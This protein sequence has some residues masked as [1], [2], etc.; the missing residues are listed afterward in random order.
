MD[1]LTPEVVQA[2]FPGIDYI[3]LVEDDGPVAAA[4]YRQKAMQG[5]IFSTLDVLRAP[6]YSST[7]FDVI[8]G[9]TMDGKVTGAVVLFHREPYLINDA[10]RTAQLEIF[11]TSM[12][13][14]EARLGAATDLPPSFVAGATISARSMRNAVQEGGRMVLSYRTEEIIVT[15]RTVD[16]VNFKPQSPEELVA[17]G[18][19]VNARI[20]NQSLNTA[21]EKAG[22]TDFLPEIAMTGGPDDLYIDFVAGYANPPMIGRNGAGLEPYDQ[23][24]NG[25]NEGHHG[26][27]VA[28]LDGV[29]DHRGVRFNNLSNQF[30]LDR[31]TVS[32]NQKNFKF[33]KS[34]MLMARG[35]EADILVLPPES[36]FD[37]MQPWQITLHAN[38]RKPNGELLPF[39][40]A[41]LDYQLS[42]NYI[43]MPEASPSAA[44]IE[45]WVE[46]KRDIVILCVALAF[47]TLM[48][49]GQDVLNSNRRLHKVVRVLFLLFTLIWI[50]WVASAQLSIVHLVNYLQAPFA[51]LDI[52]FYLMEPLIVILS[53]YTALSV[54]LIGRGVFCGWLCPFGALQELLAQIARLL[55]LPRWTPSEAVQ[56]RYWNIK[57]M[58]LGLILL[59]VVMAPEAA[60]VAQE[61]EPFKTAITAK[62]VR[63]WPYLFYAV[64]LLVI[65]LFTERAFC[66][67]LC[68]LGAGLAVLDRL[69]LLQFLKRRPE[70]CNPC[71]LCERSCPVKA[72]ESSGKIKMAECFLCLDCMVEYH[73]D[74]RCPP[75]AMARK[76][77][78]RHP[79]G[80]VEAAS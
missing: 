49:A 80:Q 12:Q 75:L 16:L 14:G 23:L 78:M 40:L 10:R 6:G 65:G 63:G 1:R 69:H 42:P 64:L 2:V 29:F 9:V 28:T 57:Y 15:E 38:A 21:L 52:T 33:E 73:D 11:L 61:I 59:L 77:A 44:W 48:L 13:G 46:G 24:I 17:K 30:L 8:A 36:G 70:C 62:F 71:H 37:P 45:P 34:D 66:R 60:P 53:V 31:I 54:I 79:A 68:P 35:K 56:Q 25:L 76:L 72:I 7:P 18:G 32:Q 67:F 5:Y 50:G 74:R 39:L 51:G 58:A 22:Y 3:E 47:L 4:A 41:S 20:T 19:L 43:L 27:L 55:K 26:I